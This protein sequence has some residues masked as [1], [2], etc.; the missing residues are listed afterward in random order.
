MGDDPY[1]STSASPTLAA[2]NSMPATQFTALLA[3]VFEHSPWVAQRAAPSRPFK[4]VSQLHQAMVAAMH[5]ATE[6]E[7]IALLCAHPE[8]AGQEA[9]HGTLT[10]ASDQE[11]A[12]AGLKALSPD[13]MAR[14]SAL[15]SAYR[16][17]HGFPFIVCV[18]Q[19]TKQ[20]L[21]SAFERRAD[22]NRE[23][24]LPEALSQVETITRLRLEAM[25][26]P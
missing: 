18:G 24:E 9:Q 25:F 11:Q 19:H 5:Q 3:D 13:E 23:T 2:L 6:A 22:N 14:I 15:N 8:L 21:F 1:N 7:K 26:A 4:D 16:A 10:V 12:R 20:S 17:R